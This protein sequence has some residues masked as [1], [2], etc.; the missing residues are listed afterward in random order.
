MKTL[1]QLAREA[2]M[3]RDGDGWFTP[4]GD[5]AGEYDVSTES[6]ARFR[7]ACRAEEALEEAAPI[8]ALA[9][10]VAEWHIGDGDECGVVARELLAKIDAIREPWCGN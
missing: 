9:A 8:F 5:P 7:A 6:L 4:S 2:G 1:E 3:E 10:A